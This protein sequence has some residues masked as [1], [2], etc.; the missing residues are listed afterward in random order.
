MT[1]ELAI[2]ILRGDVLGTNE[3][4]QE[5]IAMAVQALNTPDKKVGKWVKNKSGA[6][7]HCSCC[8][9]NNFYAYCWNSEAG[10][11]DFQDKFCPNCG[12][13]MEVDE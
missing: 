3:Q 9:A 5:A 11:D 8:G 2:R 1:R 10:K 4:T 6:G 12:S 13:R 7:W